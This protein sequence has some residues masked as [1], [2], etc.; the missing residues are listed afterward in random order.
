MKPGLLKHLLNLIPAPCPALFTYL[1]HTQS[2]PAPETPLICVCASLLLL[3]VHSHPQPWHIWKGHLS[4]LQSD[5]CS[6]VRLVPSPGHPS[7]AAGVPQLPPAQGLLCSLLPQLAGPW[8]CCTSTE[9]SS[10]PWGKGRLIIKSTI[11]IFTF[12]SLAI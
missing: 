7:S 12:C 1:D 9:T 6:P 5:T 3:S 11:E 2:T 8:F 4:T 10:A